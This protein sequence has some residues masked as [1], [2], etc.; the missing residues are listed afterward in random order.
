ML[1]SDV[2][3]ITVF[4]R[5]GASGV[6]EN[7][8]TGPKVVVKNNIP[9]CVMISPQAYDEMAVQLKE[10]RLLLNAMN[11]KGGLTTINKI[12]DKF[13]ITEEDLDSVEDDEI[14]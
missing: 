7:L 2:V 14:V 11:G 6:F 9:V 8:K 12:M 1:T 5:G 13:G 3:S 10:A 4:N